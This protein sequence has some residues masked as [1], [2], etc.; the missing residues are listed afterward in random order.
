MTKKRRR[1]D[2]PGYR[3]KKIEIS[4][5]KNQIRMKTAAGKEL[6]KDLVRKSV[7]RDVRMETGLFSDEEIRGFH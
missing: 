4:E 5:L 3:Q 1:E 2:N 6:P 7:Y